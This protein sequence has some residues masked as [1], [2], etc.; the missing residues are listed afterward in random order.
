MGWDKEDEDEETFSEMHASTCDC[1]VEETITTESTMEEV[2]DSQ[3]TDGG[4]TIMG[5]QDATYQHEFAGDPGFGT[6]FEEEYVNRNEDV[7]ETGW[8]TSDDEFP[9]PEHPPEI[10]EAPGKDELKR[11]SEQIAD[12]QSRW[13]KRSLDH[14]SAEEQDRLYIKHARRAGMTA[15][16]I[17]KL[18]VLK[19]GRVDAVGITYRMQKLKEAGKDI[20]P[21]TA[22]A[23]WQ[24]FK[25]RNS[26]LTPATFETAE[27]LK[28]MKNGKTVEEIV[29]MGIVTVGINT[30]KAV[31]HRWDSYIRRNLTVP[32]IKSDRDKDKERK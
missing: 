15:S 25:K 9:D 4:R 14:L 23:A 8:H 5:D 22:Q 28:A 18:K 1:T 21:R 30:R 2:S 10:Q 11:T 16:A 12:F 20:T 27:V 6:S 7:E 17:E 26:M 32:E 31:R 19:T 24:Q 13:A 29:E 3:E